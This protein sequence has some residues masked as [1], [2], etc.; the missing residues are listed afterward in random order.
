[1]IWPDF[2]RY[3]LHDHKTGAV[4]AATTSEAACMAA[5]RLLSPDPR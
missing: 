5:R 1:M 2:W 3:F 4:I